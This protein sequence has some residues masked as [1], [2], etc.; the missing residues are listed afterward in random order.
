MGQSETHELCL[1]Q[2]Q[3]SVLHGCSGWALSS[4]MRIIVQELQ[5]LLPL[6]ASFTSA[7]LHPQLGAALHTLFPRSRKKTA[8]GS[9]NHMQDVWSRNSPL[10]R[11]GGTP[12]L[13]NIALGGMMGRS[14]FRSVPQQHSR[15]HVQITSFF[16]TKPPTI[17]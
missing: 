8:N 9:P 13:P 16:D 10:V 17:Y 15:H 1:G 5:R 6:A 4:K 3:C 7:A 2:A 12:S 11:G 14:C